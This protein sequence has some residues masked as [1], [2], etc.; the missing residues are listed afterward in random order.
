MNEFDCADGLTGESSDLARSKIAEIGIPV[1]L[2]V[3]FK[4][5]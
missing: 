4:G 2:R 3:A 1:T 5:L